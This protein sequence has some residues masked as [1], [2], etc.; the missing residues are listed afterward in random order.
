MTETD[1]AQIERIE[2]KVGSPKEKK[3]LI[4]DSSPKY[5]KCLK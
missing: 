5:S 3:E 1:L 4:L 2:Q